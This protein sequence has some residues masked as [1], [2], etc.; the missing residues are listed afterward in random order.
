VKGQRFNNERVVGHAA[1]AARVHASRGV[2]ELLLLDV[3]ATSEG[4]GPDLEMIEELTDQ[5]FIPVTVGG[6][7]RTLDQI[8]DLLRAGAD[9]VAIGAAARQDPH[10]ILKASEKFGSQAIVV[11][12]DYP[13]QS[14][15][16]T[17]VAESNG[18]GEILLNHMER[19]GTMDG[20]DLDLI[21]F[22]S[23]NLSVPLIACGGC[24]SYEDMADAIKAGASAVAVGAFFTFED[25]T[26]LEAARYL[27]SQG[28]E[29]RL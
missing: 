25:A 22:V 27:A 4:R 21:R 1:Q 9:K 14:T 13:A 18:A 10:F 2:D 29:A 12:V 6:G 8:R 16:F 5:V 23:E 26:P 17:M 7:I 24:K 19:D 20:F 3:S 11:A 15:S 28:I